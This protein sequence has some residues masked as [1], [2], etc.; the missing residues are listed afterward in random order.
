MSGDLLYAV[1]FA[2]LASIILVPSL[3]ATRSGLIARWNRRWRQRHGGAPHGS[4]ARASL[5]R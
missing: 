5:P 1:A 3:V 2:L 4:W